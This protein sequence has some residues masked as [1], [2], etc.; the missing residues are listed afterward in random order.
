MSLTSLS[1][2]GI[3]FPLLLIVYYN[4]IIKNNVFRKIILVGAS[5]GLYAFSEPSYILLL[6]GMIAC[7]YFFG[8][9]IG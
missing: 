4:P 8:Q 5:L 6:M 7:N 1:F 2:L 9:V 3:Y